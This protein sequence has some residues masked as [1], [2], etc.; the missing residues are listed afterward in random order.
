[1]TPAAAL[2][3]TGAVAGCGSGDGTPPVRGATFISQDRLN[4]YSCSDWSR[5]RPNEQ[6]AAIDAIRKFAGG[7]I[8][9]RGAQG[10]GAVLEDEHAWRLF[11]STCQ[12]PYARHWV[13]L[14]LYTHAAA[15]A[16]R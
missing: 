10:R 9:G 15:F 13:L 12:R 2:L 16:G 1:V 7:M 8:T 3:A 6:K 4:Q 5:A 14:K 11:H